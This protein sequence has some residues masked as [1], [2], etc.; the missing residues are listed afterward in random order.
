[1]LRQ[2]PLMLVLSA[3]GIACYN[4]MCYIGLTGTTA[5]NA[6]LLQSINPLIVVLWVCAV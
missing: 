2:W 4:A 3:T 6:L 1:M 5:L